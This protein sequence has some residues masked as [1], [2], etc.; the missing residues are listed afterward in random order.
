MERAAGIKEAVGL[1]DRTIQ[2]CS[3]RQ[4]LIDLTSGNYTTSL[5]PVRASEFIRGVASTLTTCKYVVSDETAGLRVAVDEKMCRIALDNA[6]NNAAVHGGGGVIKF[7]A[8]FYP[9][10]AK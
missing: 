4:V 3:G 10:G 6:A 9:R 2:W 1:L 7:G 5:S 8:K